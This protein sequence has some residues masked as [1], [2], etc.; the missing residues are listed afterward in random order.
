VDAMCTKGVAGLDLKTGDVARGVT[1]GTERE[2]VQLER[3]LFRFA[4]G[5][6]HLLDQ[7]FG[8]QIDLDDL[9][10]SKKTCHPIE[11]L[12]Q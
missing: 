5:V 1:H 6:S 3:F 4:V 11:L 7:S 9:T 12:D 8:S 2:T 10:P